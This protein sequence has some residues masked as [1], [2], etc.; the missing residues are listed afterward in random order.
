MLHQIANVVSSWCSLGSLTDWDCQQAIFLAQW[1]SFPDFVQAQ[2]SAT[3]VIDNVPQ[4]FPSQIL[5]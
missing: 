1:F 2:W 3:I 4:F 5:M